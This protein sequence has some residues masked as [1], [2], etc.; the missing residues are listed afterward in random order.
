MTSVPSTPVQC[1]TLAAVCVIVNLVGKE[2]IMSI[3]IIL[4]NGSMSGLVLVDAIYL[5]QSLTITL[6][7]CNIW[8]VVN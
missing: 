4:L 3:S 5:G 6:V 7:K 8:K 2:K 1:T